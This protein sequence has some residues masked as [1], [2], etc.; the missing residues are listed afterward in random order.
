M[1]T[2][3]LI[4]KEMLGWA[5]RRSLGNLDD[6]AKYLKIDKYKLEKW[7][8]GEAYPTFNQAQEIARKLKIPF[9]YL[10]LS[11]PPDESLP[12]PDLRVK[13][14]T[15]SI[16]PSPDFLEILYSAMRKQEWYRDYMTNEDVD[17]VPFVSRYTMSSPIETVANDVRKALNLDEDFRQK[18]RDK[19]DF[20]TKLVEQTE[21][22]GV[23]VMRSSIV[24]NNT[25]RKLDPNEFQGFAMSD[26]YAPLVFVNQN[27]YLS[28]QIFTLMHELAH[29]WLGVSGVSIQDYLIEPIVQDEVIQRRANEIAAE[30]LV[31]AD[32]LFFRWQSYHDIDQGLE[33]LTR[34]YRVSI[35][36]VL[37]RIYTLGIIPFSLYQ[38]KYSELKQGIYHKKKGGGG[39]LQPIFS[40]NSTTITTALLNAV[41]EGTVL[42]SHASKLLNVKPTT[43]YNMQAFLAGK[44]TLRA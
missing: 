1:A 28:A 43:L 39:G 21:A 12:L 9:G 31:P 24:G 5:I 18:T 3:A 8:K 17:P 42:P 38:A 13:P 10:Y 16:R 6:A 7:E 29:I 30:I 2:E 27:D 32:E 14:G 41:S 35:F 23:L 11:G 33:D 20:Y 19:M 26:K 22:S 37:R 44:G 15:Q 25:R 40:R 36:V 34:Y 4:K